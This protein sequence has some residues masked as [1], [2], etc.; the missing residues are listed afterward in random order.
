M[1]APAV[2]RRSAP[3][4][5]AVVFPPAHPVDLVVH[6]AMN[7]QVVYCNHHTAALSVRERLAFSSEEQLLRAYDG[8]RA[9]FPNSEHVVISTCNRVELYSAQEDPADAPNA[10]QVAEFLSEFHQLP[11]QDF[12]GDLLQSSGP[13]AVKHLFEVASS[14][15]SMVLGETQIVNQVKKAYEAATRSET[16]GPLTNALFQR[17]LL[18]SSRVRTETR[19]VEGKI[20]IASVAVGEF[21]KSIFSSFADKQVL[22]L[23][24]GEMAVETL[25]YLHEEGVHRIIL[26]NRSRERA[27]PL[28]EEFGGEYRPWSDLNELLGQADVIISTTGATEPVVR[29]EQFRTIRQRTGQ[30]PLFIL[31]LGAPR[32]FEPAIG[33]LD[34]NVFLY[35]IDDLEA[36]CEKNRK[37]R[38]REVAKAE[39]II[40]EETERFLQDVYH[41]ATGPIIKQLREQWHEVSRKELEILFR[42]LPHLSHEDRE[43]IDKTLQRIVNKL[44]H[45]PLETL[46]DEAKVGTPHGLMEA[47]RKLFLRQ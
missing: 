28:V 17:A 19:L 12:L 11:V 39:Q 23:G 14:I 27:I 43:A 7:V 37:L 13:A 47:I 9:R 18:V 45:P 33:D 2:T 16:N 41:K 30:K 44:L 31:D 10:V 4:E 6:L 35:D 26:C 38:S 25:R 5:Q 20:S 22:V 36:T 3:V 8:L 32:D 40:H 42:K 34:D 1:P 29:V 21:G 15:D 46:R 24:A